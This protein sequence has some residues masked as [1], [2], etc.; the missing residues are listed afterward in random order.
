MK[1]STTLR[2]LMTLFNCLFIT[3]SLTSWEGLSAEATVSVPQQQPSGCGESEPMTDVKT[4][5][6]ANPEGAEIG[7]VKDFVLD[8]EAGRIAY[9]VGVFDQI[10]E[11]SNRMFVIPWEGVKV[12]LETNTFTLNEDKAV[13]ESAPS[14]APDPWPNLPTSQ[15]TAIV[16]GYWKEKLGH[17]FAAVGTP[18][19]ALYKASDVVGMTIKN[20]TG[21]DVGTIEELMLDPEVG[22]IAYAVLSFEDTRRSNHTVFF[23]LPWDLVRVNP[24]QHTFVADVDKKML[25]ESRGVSHERLGSNSSA[26]APHRSGSQTQKH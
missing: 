15:W 22:S 7:T 23:A 2:T 25:T 5:V 9:I 19:S 17:S 10:G 13:L 24:V 16:S 14:F 12:D 20:L 8:L 26:G 4:G 11:S 6:I 1:K 18:E 3:S 21:K